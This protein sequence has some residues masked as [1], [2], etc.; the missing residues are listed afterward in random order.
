MGKLLFISLFLTA[1]S[2][3]LLAQ[4]DSGFTN[5]S[6]AK[7]QMVN[8]LKE[9]KWIEYTNSDWMP[10]DSSGTYYLLVLYKLDSPVGI[11][12]GYYK[13]GKLY[14]LF[15]NKNGKRNGLAK[16]YYKSGKLWWAI[17]FKDGETEGVTKEY[18]ESGK[19][20]SAIKCS[21]GSEGAT[22]NYD[23]NGNEIK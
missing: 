4:Q 20:K 5:K 6:E 13:D 1:Y 21:H 10:A 9:G 17:P 18:Y 11:V 12:H 22:K 14:C 3:S 7:N 23:E 19:L 2:L 15:P 8:G 16:C